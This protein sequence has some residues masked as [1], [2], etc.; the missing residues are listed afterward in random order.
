ETALAYFEKHYRRPDG[1]FRT[2]VAADGT[3]VDDEARLYDQAFALL[4]W[5]ATGEEGKAL[6]LISRLDA[7]RHPAGGWR[8]TGARPVQANAH[9]HQFEAAQAWAAI[10][11]NPVW[12]G[13]DDEIGELAMGRFFK[14]G[15][16]REAYDA[17][18]NAATGG[19][20]RLVEPGH[21]FEWAHLLKAWGRPD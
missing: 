17:A 19:E 3:V 11:K 6:D 8:E 18:W 4:A 9:V 15:V 20:G 14:D 16:I 5:S 1:L 10:S 13:I 2:L 21:L 7:W 12:T